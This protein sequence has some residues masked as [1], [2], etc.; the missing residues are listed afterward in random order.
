MYYMRTV[1]ETSFV[2]KLRIYEKKFPCDE[3]EYENDTRVQIMYHM[4]T[5]HETCF[6]YQLRISFWVDMQKFFFQIFL[7]I[8]CHPDLKPVISS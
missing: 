1:H 8:L 7:M 2:Y 4:R 3:C 5:D 6:V